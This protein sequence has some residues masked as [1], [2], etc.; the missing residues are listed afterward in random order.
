MGK[1]KKR[2]QRNQPAQNGREG[3]SWAMEIARKHGVGV[4]KL[5]EQMGSA[6]SRSEKDKAFANQLRAKAR[7]V[8]LRIASEREAEEQA[9]SM[10]NDSPQVTGED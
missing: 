10:N 4:V 5:V 8:A 9:L 7:E 3:C 6:T 2:K 1:P